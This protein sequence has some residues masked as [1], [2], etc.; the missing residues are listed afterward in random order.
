M[1]D[2][3]LLGLIKVYNSREETQTFL[4]PHG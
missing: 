2:E 3:G 4:L 1:V